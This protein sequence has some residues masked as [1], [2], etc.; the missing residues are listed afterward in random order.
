MRRPLVAVVAVC[1]LFAC[2]S[3]DLAACGD[4][5]A[6]VGR[7]S[8]LKAYA[9]LFP[10]S[11]L[12]YAPVDAK[13]ADRK[14]FESLLTHAGH[15]PVFVMHGGDI[16]KALAAKKYDLLIVSYADAAAV[17]ARVRAAG[18]G[19][20]IVPILSEKSK[21]LEPQ[22]QKDYHFLI[23]PYSMSKWDALEELDHAMDSRIKAAP[24]TT[25]LK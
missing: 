21:K 4:K 24:V 13:A 1:V 15:S 25:S 20:T 17:T 2:A 14:E 16:E 23:T 18:G 9:P 3:I 12:V 22:V 11:V 5:Y 7:S 10:A 19:P 8:R 6:R